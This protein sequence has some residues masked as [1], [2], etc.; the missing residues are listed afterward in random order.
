M[1]K[2]QIIDTV[3][4]ITDSLYDGII[5]PS[6]RGKLIPFYDEIIINDEV[7]IASWDTRNDIIEIIGVKIKIDKKLISSQ[8]PHII[9]IQIEDSLIKN[10]DGFIV[11][12]H[13]DGDIIY[14]D[15]ERNL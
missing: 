11:N 3:K 7:D 14:V 6:Y 5:I 2:Q 1:K 10:Y 12:C 8:F 4:S 9:T 15:L 13:L